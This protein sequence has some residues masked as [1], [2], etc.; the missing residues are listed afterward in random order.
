MNLDLLN[1]KTTPMRKLLSIKKVV[2]SKVKNRLKKVVYRCFS[3][4]IVLE[5]E[6]IAAPR[7]KPKHL[8]RQS[9]HKHFP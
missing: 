2:I 7:Q 9:S 4:F 3:I 6:G 8:S 5:L 1:S